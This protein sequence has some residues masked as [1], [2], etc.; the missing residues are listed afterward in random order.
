MLVLFIAL[1]IISGILI[2][3]DPHNRATRWGSALA[4]FSGFGGLGI[5]LREFSFALS[6]TNT[7]VFDLPVYTGL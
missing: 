2:R 5:F 7:N 6:D 1:W 4:F 3:T